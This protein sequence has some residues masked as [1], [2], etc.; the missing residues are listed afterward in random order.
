MKS[1]KH[2]SKYPMSGENITLFQGSISFLLENYDNWRSLRRNLFI[3]LIFRR[4][5][6]ERLQS[7][8]ESSYTTTQVIKLFVLLLRYEYGDNTYLFQTVTYMNE[9]EICLWK[10][11]L[12][13]FSCVLSLISK[14]S[15]IK[16]SEKQKEKICEP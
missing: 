9:R 2:C 6:L 12:P 14:K 16:H 7:I 8:R 1:A 11:M 3:Y 10:R 15:L 5:T 13:F 4:E